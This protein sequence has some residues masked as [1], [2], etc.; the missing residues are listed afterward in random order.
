MKNVAGE[1]K[2]ISSSSE[3]DFVF[4][5]G[6]FVKNEETEKELIEEFNIVPL[7]YIERFTENEATI[8]ESECYAPIL[9]AFLRVR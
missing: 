7:N 3:D 1:L 8:K 2:E 9:G 6:G 5:K 4:G